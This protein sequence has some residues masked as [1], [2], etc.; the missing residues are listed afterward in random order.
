MRRVQVLLKSEANMNRWRVVVG[1]VL[2]NLALGSLYAWSVFVLPLEQEFGW[3]RA[4]TSW[5]YTIAIVTFAATF[6]VAGRI[7]DKRGPRLC[8]FLGA[9]LV[10]LGFF[11]TS[12]TTSLWFLYVVFGI[13]VGAGNGFGYA[14]PI[15]VASKWFPD[16]RGLVVGMMVG[17]YGAG[18]AI[19]GPLATN[20]I[21]SIGWRPTFQLLSA[22][23]LVMG[24]IGTWLMT[25]PPQGYRPAGWTPTAAASARRDFSTVEM[26]RTPQFYQLWIAYCLGTTAGQMTISQLVPF[27]RS[28]GLGAAAAAF[29]ITVGAVGNAGGRILS[30]W[31]SDAVGRLTTLR[32]MILASAVAMPALFAFR[33]Q[34][35][36]FYILVAAVYWCYGTQLSV[37]ASTTADFYG[38]RNLGLNYGVLF[39]AWGA[40]G[41]LGPIIGGRVFDA[42]GD[43]RYAFYAA[44]GLAIVAFASLALARS[45][46]TAPISAVGAGAAQANQRV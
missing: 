42:F 20:L 35:L 19:V 14:T 23:F 43:Y 15:P 3:T 37:F 41:I 28:A 30:G 29:A 11:V 21:G 22:V 9:V 16:K 25:N 32:I 10:S 27:A 4:Q 17:G 12:L 34:L 5:V 36:L 24:L 26:L 38:T 44:S 1:G 2:M 45:V 31:L 40:A 7:Q 46:V 13:V 6:I 8:A 33:E 39:T 18:S